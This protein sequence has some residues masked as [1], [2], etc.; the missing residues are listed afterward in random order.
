MVLVEVVVVLAVL[1]SR[2]AALWCSRS[3]VGGGA[4]AKAQLGPELAPPGVQ[5]EGGLAPHPPHPCEGGVEGGGLRPVGVEAVG[6]VHD[7]VGGG[8]GG[9]AAITGLAILAACCLSEAG[10]VEGRSAFQE[11]W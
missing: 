6:E 1:G 2:A 8:H 10:A 3:Q 7:V 4:Q 11:V 5:G 9:E